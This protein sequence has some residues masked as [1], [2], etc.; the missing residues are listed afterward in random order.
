[1]A[2][3]IIFQILL[4]QIMY[5]LSQEHSRKAKVHKDKQPHVVISK[6]NKYHSSHSLMLKD[7]IMGEILELF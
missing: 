6:T 1:M 5:F 7:K 3:W 2:N 4:A